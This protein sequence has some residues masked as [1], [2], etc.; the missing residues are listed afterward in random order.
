MPRV[1]IET[2]VSLT[3]E[4]K[5]LLLDTVLDAIV[6]ALELVPDDRTGSVHVFDERA[7]RMKPPYRYFIEICL[8]VGRSR[9]VK[10]RL[11]ATIVRHLEKKMGIQ[12]D[13][14][15]IMLNEQPRENW[16]LRGGIPAD[17]ISFDYTIE[18]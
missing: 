13:T 6:S 17:E 9:D 8:F 18:Q 7:F 5:R 1:K 2:G 15:M 10:K 14:V 3:N 4:R 12:A 11:Y 16:G